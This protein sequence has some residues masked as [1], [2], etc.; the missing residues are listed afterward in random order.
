MLITCKS[1]KN[2]WAFVF[3][4]LLLST[5]HPALASEKIK[6]IMNGNMAGLLEEGF[7]AFNEATGIEVEVVAVTNWNDMR[8]KL[9]VLVIGGV[10]PDVVYHDDKTQSEFYHRGIVQPIERFVQR[11]RLNLRMWPDPVINAYRYDGQLYSLPTA[12]SNWVVFYN[13]DIMHA[14]GL[15][16]LPTDWN[17]DAFTF[18]DVLAMAKTLTRDINGDGQ[19]DQYGLSSFMGAGSLE[20]IHLWE[21]D[22]FNASQTEFIGHRPE[23]LAAITE[24][25]SLY[26]AGVMGGSWSQGT[27]AIMPQ[28]PYCLNTLATTMSTSGLFSWSLGVLP[29]AVSRRTQPGFH[30]LGMVVDAA[31][32]EGAWQFIKYMATDSVGSVL[33]ARAENR[34]P[35]SPR[36]IVD[37]NRRWETLNPGM[38]AMVFTT[39]FEHI[40]RANW[41]GLPR[42]IYDTIGSTMQRIMRMQQDPKSAMDA[43]KP[44]LDNRL[45]EIRDTLRKI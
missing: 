18:E 44:V 42:D 19:I 7:A 40:L 41:F 31:N 14:S 30:S 5:L 13:V 37:F 43:L 6:V 21:V 25:R 35:L 32:P 22:W 9:P 20:A 23:T 26:E 15:D 3:T 2:L 34:T 1:K 4:V 38:N 24:L 10:G 28:Q 45:R 39:G 8:E 33:F 27:A 12:L 29:K 16:S 11:D 17:G 36:A